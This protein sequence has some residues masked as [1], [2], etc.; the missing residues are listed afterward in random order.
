MTPPTHNARGFTLIEL[1]VVVAIVAIL[2]GI[3]YPSYVDHVRRARLTDAQM[4]LMEAAQWMERMYAVG[5]ERMVG[6]EK[7]K[8]SPN[9]Y[10]STTEFKTSGFTRS[11]KESE[12][13]KDAFYLITKTPSTRSEDYILTAT[14]AAGQQSRGCKSI[15]IGDV[16]LREAN[17]DGDKT[18]NEMDCWK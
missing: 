18:K 4:V 12:E 5:D 1:M 9:D 11:P 3:A 13:D 2:A 17:I 15:F 6:D 16:G 7:I 14:P 8:I 10:P